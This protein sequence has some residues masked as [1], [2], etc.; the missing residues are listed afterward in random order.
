[1]ICSKQR[2]ESDPI[3]HGDSLCADCLDLDCVCEY[4]W[5]RS[6]LLL[7][8]MAYG[9]GPSEDACV[10][11]LQR[12]FFIARWVTRDIDVD[13]GSERCQDPFCTDGS[14]TELC[15][16][17]FAPSPCCVGGRPELLLTVTDPSVAIPHSRKCIVRCSSVTIILVSDCPS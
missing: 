8:V 7:C 2:V 9:P 12:V 10:R 11:G 16:F 5:I 15:S 6:Y 4:D 3:N 13:L 1:V 17:T 14:N